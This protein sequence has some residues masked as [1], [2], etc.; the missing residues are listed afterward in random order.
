MKI[1]SI[2][3][4]T[5]AWVVFG[6]TWRIY[7]LFLKSLPVFHRDIR[8]FVSFD[9]CQTRVRQLSDKTKMQAPREKTLDVF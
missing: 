6:R 8:T 2:D 4:A 7:S 1:Q 5:F 3:S 9:S